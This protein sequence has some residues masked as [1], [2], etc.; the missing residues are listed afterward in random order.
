M[1]ECASISDKT[2]HEFIDYHHVLEL[3]RYGFIQCGIA[4]CWE[5]FTISRKNM[6]KHMLLYTVKGQGWLESNGQ[7]YELEPGSLMVVPAGISNT[8]GI[9]QEEWRIAWVFLEPQKNW[10]G[11]VNKQ[12]EYYLSSVTEAIYAAILLLLRARMPPIAISGEIVEATTAQLAILV[13]A[14]VEHQ[15]SGK[16]LRLRRV[17]DEAQRQLHKEWDVEQLAAL[18]PCSPPHFHRLCNQYFAHSPMTYLTKKRMEYASRLLLSTDWAV[19][20]IGELVGY[21]ILANF[22][23]RFKVWSAQTPSQYRRNNGEPI[24]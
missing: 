1:Q 5:L 6:H 11:L 10:Q 20:H 24:M 4:H 22:S 12:L 8:F 14:S 13:K 15:L 21:P 3:E 19:Q 18:Y 2:E 16:Q 9:G 17:F 23:A 7:K